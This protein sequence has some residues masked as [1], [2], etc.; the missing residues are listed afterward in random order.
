LCI[1]RS[2]I[3]QRA[4]ERRDIERIDTAVDLPD[5]ALERHTS[6]RDR[7]LADFVAFVEMVVAAINKALADIKAD[8]TYQK[9]NAKYFPFDIY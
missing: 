1:G 8:G 5:L 6:Y 7:P 2:D 9:I 3:A 4:K